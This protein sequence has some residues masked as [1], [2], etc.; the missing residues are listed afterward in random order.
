MNRA[1]VGSDR[2]FSIRPLR[3]FVSADQKL[4]CKLFAHEIVGGS[5]IIIGQGSEGSEFGSLVQNVARTCADKRVVVAVT[6]PD[7]EGYF[8]KEFGEFGAVELDVDFDAD[9]YFN[10]LAAFPDGWPVNSNPTE[11]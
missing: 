5:K 9:G 8:Y 4:Q 7:P 11:L 1:F 2:Q 10:S 3:V 6:D